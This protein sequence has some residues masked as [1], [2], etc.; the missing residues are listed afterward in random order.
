M[1]TEV[2]RYETL[3]HRTFQSAQRATT[4]QSRTSALSSHLSATHPNTPDERKIRPFHGNYLRKPAPCWNKTMSADTCQIWKDLPSTKAGPN[5]GCIYFQC[6]AVWCLNQ[7]TLLSLKMICI[8]RLMITS[9][10]Y[11]MVK[12]KCKLISRCIHYKNN[13]TG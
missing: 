8:L 9:K 11:G 10:I 12:T 1:D 3:S 4:F 2:Y 5:Q 6:T 7:I 13:S